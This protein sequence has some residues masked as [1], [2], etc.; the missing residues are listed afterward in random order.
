MQWVK[1]RQCDQRSRI[2][3]HDDIPEV[4]EAGYGESHG[5][6]TP[7]KRDHSGS[8]K[9]PRESERTIHVKYQSRE[10]PHSVEQPQSVEQLGQ[11]LY[12]DRG[13]ENLKLMK[14]TSLQPS[15]PAVEFSYSLEKEATDSRE[16][17]SPEEK[18]TEQMSAKTD[19][20]DKNVT[21]DS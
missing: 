1:E 9:T 3:K 13:L 10:Q 19:S 11:A 8:N 2:A 4:D 7:N 5:R 12:N 18:F 15:K 6:A 21:A 14:P 17:E 16:K 20:N